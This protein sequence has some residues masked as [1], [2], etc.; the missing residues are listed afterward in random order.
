MPNK[1]AF[2]RQ[3]S[4]IIKDKELIN[5]NNINSNEE[6]VSNKAKYDEDI[7][8][9]NLTYSIETETLLST[10]VEILNKIEDKY[11]LTKDQ[12]YYYIKSNDL[13]I[14]LKFD[15]KDQTN[16]LNDILDS[17]HEL[18]LA[19]P[20][21]IPL[22]TN[23]VYFLADKRF[24][25]NY[26]TFSR[27]I[28]KYQDSKMMEY[29]LLLAELL[30][31]PLQSNNKLD[32]KLYS[33][34]CELME[35]RVFNNK[36]DFKSDITPDDIEYTIKKLLSG[37]YNF[38]AVPYLELDHDTLVSWNKDLFNFNI[39]S[40]QT[41]ADYLVYSCFNFIAKQVDYLDVNDYYLLREQGLK[42]SKATNVE[43][44]AL[45]NLRANI[46]KRNYSWQEA[47]EVK[48]RIKNLDIANSF[49]FPHNIDEI[50]SCFNINLMTLHDQ[51]D[52]DIKLS[53]D[54]TD[55]R[56]CVKKYVEV[57]QRKKLRIDADVMRPLFKTKSESYIDEY[58]RRMILS[59][60]SLSDIEVDK[61]ELPS[62]QTELL[63]GT[64]LS[65]A[66]VD[67]L[68]KDNKNTTEIENLAYGVLLS[69]LKEPIKLDLKKECLRIQSELSCDEGMID[70]FN[71]N[72]I[73]LPNGDTIESKNYKEIDSIFK[74]YQGN[75]EY[76]Y[77]NANDLEFV[78]GCINIFSSLIVDQFFIKGN[79]RTAK[80]LLNK[81]L[82]SRGI[83]PPI[84]DLNENE[85][86]LF[87]DIA[88]SR[89]S[90]YD[91]VRYKLLLQTVDV[92]YKFK[93]NHFSEPLNYVEDENIRNNIYR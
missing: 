88:I 61:K 85:F 57:L 19:F 21:L 54:T 79:K 60:I 10:I 18:I 28:E 27:L 48:R 67:M 8:V 2:D 50:K 7:F 92:A 69:L 78:E 73:T 34:T 22:L 23:F 4:I 44:E 5:S 42:Q 68:F 75:Y 37:N 24:S 13:E 12:D 59:I 25:E 71:K 31:G 38:L 52:E 36:Y 26:V 87:D 11:T 32:V 53:T 9:Y 64:Y 3:Q 83:I 56:E 70:S 39:T 81:M 1:E 30:Y 41:I 46:L 35:Y 65:E 16:I 40:K 49:S 33:I 93:T 43:K 6:Y 14:I 77:D 72:E 20:E 58:I 63:K 55:L 47:Q 80:C 89:E 17:N 86:E 91:R 62:I 29:L 84:A 90:E 66:N 51:I 45:E 74:D 76:L 15:N 82:L